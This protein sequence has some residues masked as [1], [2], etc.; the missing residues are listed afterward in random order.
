MLNLLLELK[1]EKAIS[2]LNYQFAR[3][4]DNKQKPYGYSPWSKI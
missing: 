1:Q 2:D 3:F 4:I